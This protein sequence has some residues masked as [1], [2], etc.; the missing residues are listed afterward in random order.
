MVYLPGSIIKFENAAFCQRAIG[1]GPLDK[2]NLSEMHVRVKK[3]KL[4][5]NKGLFRQ[6]GGR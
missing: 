1:D 5:N 6:K 2:K 4:A 3:D